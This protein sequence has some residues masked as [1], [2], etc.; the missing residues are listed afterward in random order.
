M[1]L[2]DDLPG[3]IAFERTA[4][5]GSFTAAARELGISLSVVSKRLANFEQ[6]LSIHLLNRSTR[7]L[8][9][10]DEGRQLFAHATRVIAELKLAQE[11][12]IRQSEGVSGVLKIT[13]PNGLGRR[14][15]VPLLAGFSSLHP[16]LQIQ[17]QLSDDVLDLISHGFDLALRYGELPDSSL[18]ARVLAPNRRVLCA[19]PGYLRRRGQPQKLADLAR[20]DCIHIGSTAGTEWHF[21]DGQSVHITA[22]AICNDGEAAHAMSL[23]GMGIVLKSFLDVAADLA[24]GNLIQLLPQ[25]AVSAAPLNAVYPRGHQVT[26]R[27]RA[28]IDYIAEQLAPRTLLSGNAPDF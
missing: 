13:A 25:H 27:L 15:I 26:P 14:R 23:A 28:F 8:S 2:I 22:R 20:H 12:L 6:R 4:A 11:T 24:S 3:L 16:Q 19:S 7:R 5:L 17:L 21:D 10:T 18:I 1:N 9:L